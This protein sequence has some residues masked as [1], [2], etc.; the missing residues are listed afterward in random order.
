MNDFK[1][2]F[3]DFALKH[4]ILKFGNFTLKSGRKSPYYFNTGICNNGLLLNELT[5]YYIDLILS[6]SS[7]FEFIYGPAYKGIPLATSISLRLFHE[8]KKNKPYSF[9]RKEIKKHGDGGEIVGYIKGGKALVVDDVIS[10]GSSIIESIELLKKHDSSCEDIVV[11]LDRMEI[12]KNERASLEM[13]NLGLK[14]YSI[15]TLDDIE[16]Y[17]ANNQSLSHH[18]NSM[19]EYTNTYKR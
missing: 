18:L 10:S 7:D 6:S 13:K 3:I 4:E 15:I 9:N 1:K 19:K 17:L 12:G 16:Q 11:A 14:V 5:S 2:N 8:H